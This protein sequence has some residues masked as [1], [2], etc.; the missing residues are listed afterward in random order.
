MDTTSMPERNPIQVFDQ[1]ALAYDAWFDR[2]LDLFEKELAALRKAVPENTPGVDI[3]AGTGRFTRALGVPLAVEP[4]AAMSAIALFRDIPVVRA[5]AAQ[6]PFHDASFH[7]ALMVTTVCFLPDIPAAFGEV[8]RI[9][10]PGGYFII[11]LVDRN[12]PLG[13]S[14]EAQKAGNPWYRDAHFHSVPEI[15]GL[16][17]N[18]GFGQFEYWQTLFAQ[19]APGMDPRQGFGEGSFVVIRCQ[20]K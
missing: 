19:D 13:K 17:G 15:T 2:H 14:Y 9:L 18:S 11:G 1:N 4:S 6:M 16:L 10:Q 5:E 20:K 12:S 7:Y 3:G 8:H